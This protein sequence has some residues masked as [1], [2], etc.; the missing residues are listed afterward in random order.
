MS[1][2]AS[3]RLLLATTNRHKAS[4][5]AA[6]LKPF[7]LEVDVPPS[8]AP[9]VEDGETF[10]ENAAIK[11]RA[12][13]RAAGRPALADD[14]GIV[15]PSLDGEPGVRSA[16]YAGLGATDEQNVALLLDRVR[17]RALADP[18]AEFVCCAVLCA[19]DGS[20]VA[21]SEGRVEGVVR[22][23]PRGANGFGYDPVF[24]WSGPG[25]PAG[26][27]RFAELAPSAKDAVSHRGLAFRAIARLV[28]ELPPEALT[29]ETG[30][31]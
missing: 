3:R 16:R 10:R 23:P 12:A 7:G 27:A 8:L 31:L 9:V 30:P 26:G 21:E 1:A 28:L 14:S 13:A 15:V 24:H 25:A 6:I 19:P 4:E 11:A 18:R 20:V 17:R 22:G 5:I 2:A 29:E